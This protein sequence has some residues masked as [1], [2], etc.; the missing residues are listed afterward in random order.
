M[1]LFGRP[2]PPPLSFRE[3][4][5]E[6]E[7]CA[8]EALLLEARFNRPIAKND[9]FLKLHIP[10]ELL[11]RVTRAISRDVRVDLALLGSSERDRLERESHD[12]IVRALAER[13][14]PIEK[15]GLTLADVAVLSPPNRSLVDLQRLF[16][17]M[18]AVLELKEL[19]PRIAM[20]SE[21]SRLLPRAAALPADERTPFRLVRD[22][23]V[24]IYTAR[25]VKAALG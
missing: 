24:G 10:F 17:Y 7:R 12:L 15:R 21:V 8:K 6:I 23:D 5:A 20:P 1:S 4:E 11:D 3:R 18:R 25:L 14:K 9:L 2:T 13:A 22:L 16:G 19:P